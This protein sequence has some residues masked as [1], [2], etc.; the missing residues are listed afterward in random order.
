MSNQTIRDSILRELYDFA[1]LNPERYISR[2][3]LLKKLRIN[4]KV[5]AF[6]IKYLEDKGLI[7]SQKFFGGGFLAQITIYGIDFVESELE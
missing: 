4:K 2:E 1:L 3:E 7:N 5:L 6:N